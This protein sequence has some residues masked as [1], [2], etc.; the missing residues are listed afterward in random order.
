MWRYQKQQTALALTQAT[1][2]VWAEGAVGM[3]SLIVY[4]FNGDNVTLFL[5]QVNRCAF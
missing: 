3:I 4:C 1:R 2:N 5:H